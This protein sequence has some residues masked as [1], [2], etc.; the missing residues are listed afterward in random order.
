MQAPAKINKTGS[1][2][3]YSRFG[4]VISTGIGDI[5]GLLPR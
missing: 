3:P 4:A 5:S 1:S 2:S